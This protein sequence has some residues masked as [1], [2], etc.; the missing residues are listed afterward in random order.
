MSGWVGMWVRGCVRECTVWRDARGR[1]RAC[2]YFVSYRI[3]IELFCIVLCEHVH[4]YLCRHA[5][6]AR[7]VGTTLLRPSPSW[8]CVCVSYI[9]HTLDSPPPVTL[10]PEI[11]LLAFLMCRRA[12]RSSALMTGGALVPA[13]SM[14]AMCVRARTCVRARVW[15]CVIVCDRDGRRVSAGDVHVRR[16]RVCVCACAC[17]CV[18][19]CARMWWHLETR[20]E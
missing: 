16:T 15:V 2:C 8:S 13:T 17:D 12:A 10:S 14:S 11:L 6:T 3:A 20:C 1:A 18:R 19:L 5:L 4:V 7:T 9:T